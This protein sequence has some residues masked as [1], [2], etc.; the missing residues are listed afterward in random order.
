MGVSL[1]VWVC[2]CVCVYMCVHVHVGL[3]VCVC[4]VAMTAETWLD[5]TS[6]CLMSLFLPLLFVKL[7][8][9][10]YNNNLIN[11][12]SHLKYVK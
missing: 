4:P 10:N 6:L 11:Q 5:L 12:P 3:W 1:C 8:H 2:M 7:N 9:L